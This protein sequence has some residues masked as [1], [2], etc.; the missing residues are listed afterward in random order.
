MQPSAGELANEAMVDW[1]IADGALWSPAL[2]GAFRPTPR[3]CFLDRVFQFQPKHDR[4]R[5]IITRDPGPEELRVVYSDRALITRLSPQT[6]PGPEMPISSSSQPTLMAS[7]LEDVQLAQG[8]R[9]L[10][11]GAGT[12]YNAALMAHVVGP[13]LVTSI[14][15]DREVLSE[16]WDHLR[17]F[18]DRQVKLHHADGRHGF[19]EA[20]PFDRI[21]IT[22]AT[23]D[24]ELAWLEQL[25]KQGRLLAPLAL[26]PGLAF[27]V[28]GG[29]SQGIFEGQLTRAAYF[30]PLRAEGETGL[31]EPF[32]PHVLDG[33]RSSSAPWASWFDRK[34]PRVNWLRFIQALAFYG[35]L[36]GLDVEY[37]TLPNGRPVYGVSAAKR[38]ASEADRAPFCWLGPKQWEASGPEGRDLGWHLWRDFLD[39]GG[40]W[41]TEFRLQACP[42]GQLP[43]QG[44]RE[45]YLR[46]GP[47]TQQRWQLIETRRRST[48]I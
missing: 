27:V 15:V 2:I 25:T 38:S 37:R 6:P 24:L 42:H 30:M 19:A 31:D 17:R 22:A 3:N 48:W 40:P 9:V 16:A 21:M 47:R 33:V 26:A 46:T 14:D 11:V 43:P 44:G 29:M 32:R 34:R 7:M 1:M 10:E 13:G 45:E 23:D 12:G 36:R 28:C 4:W 18:P 35:W 41:P 8:Q 5:E 20:A 39:A